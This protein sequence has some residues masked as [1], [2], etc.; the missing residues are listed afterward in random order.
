MS[1][2]QTTNNLNQQNISNTESL[3]SIEVLVDSLSR[4]IRNLNLVRIK[5]DSSLKELSK[6]NG[7]T[8][9]ALDSLR[10]I[11]Q[12]NSKLINDTEVSF[13]NFSKTSST[14]AIVLIIGILL[15]V[16][17]A[18]LLAGLSLSQKI[19]PVRNVR[20]EYTLG[21]LAI[22]D[23]MKNNVMNFYGIIGSILLV[24]GFCL[25]FSGTILVIGISFWMILSTILGALVVAFGLLFFLMGQTIDQTRKE[26]L[27]IIF[28]NL[29]RI[30]ISPI[31]CKLLNRRKIL[32]EICT[33]P[34]L[35]D[36]AQ[37]WYKHEQN[38][39]NHPFL[40]RPYGFYLGHEKCLE[41]VHPTKEPGNGLINKP[42][43]IHKFNIKQFYNTKLPE[44]KNW[45]LRHREHWKK[46]RKG[47][48]EPP[49]ESEI[50]I[51]HLDKKLSK[52][53]KTGKKHII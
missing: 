10:K 34:V 42:H 26:K 46:Q 15:E 31:H 11:I 52:K 18:T 25:Q 43:P 49:N 50:S 9:K 40:H 16:I 20:L 22:E 7:I 6:Q 12:S 3:K 36:E 35:L 29:K 27:K 41:K 28:L 47:Y 48:S 39:E 23:K 33:K 14:G 37:V 53:F 1:F 32:C 4:E 19:E 21:D 8:V 45:I 51:S 38:S 13:S 17:G 24:L 2:S 44:L 30:I 5:Q